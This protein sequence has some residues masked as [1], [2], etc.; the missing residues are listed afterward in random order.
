LYL[1]EREKIRQKKSSRLHRFGCS[2]SVNS[3]Q[4]LL[5]FVSKSCFN[6]SGRSRKVA[7]GAATIDT[8]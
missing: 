2:F 5:G 7:T 8:K 1:T 3:I 4:L 6:V